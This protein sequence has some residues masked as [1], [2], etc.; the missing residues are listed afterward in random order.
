MAESDLS[1]L[2]SGK[3]ETLDV[4]YKAWMDTSEA[5]A[6]KHAAILVVSTMS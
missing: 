2:V 5:C 6:E 3:S 1:E 4:E